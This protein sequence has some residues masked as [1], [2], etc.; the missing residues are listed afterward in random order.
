MFGFWKMPC[1]K[2]K[3]KREKIIE[4]EIKEMKEIEEKEKRKKGSDSLLYQKENMHVFAF[5]STL[6]ICD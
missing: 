4:I 1:K 5:S 2:R 6:S 3:K